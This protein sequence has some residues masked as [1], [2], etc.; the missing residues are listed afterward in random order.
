MR[1]PKITVGQLKTALAEFPD[2]WPLT[3]DGLTFRRIR[4]RGTRS[5]NIEFAELIDPLF[6]HIARESTTDTVENVDAGMNGIHRTAETSAILKTGADG[7][8]LTN[9]K[10]LHR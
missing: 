3:F 2:H 8:R 4:K 9:R 5:A 10:K 7:R 6:L 1:Y